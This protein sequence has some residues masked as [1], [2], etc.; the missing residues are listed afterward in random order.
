GG[1]GDDRVKSICV[2]EDGSI[3]FTGYFEETI[4]FS[5]KKEK[6]AIK[7]SAGSSDMYITKLSSDGLFCWSRKFGGSGVD[8]GNFCIVS[9]SKIYVT[10]YFYK[11]V[12]FAAEWNKSDI[13]KSSGT[14]DSFVIVID[15]KGNYVQTYKISSTDYCFAWGMC[16][17]KAQ[18]IYIT[19]EFHGLITSDTGN[20]TLQTTSKGIIDV[21]IIK[22]E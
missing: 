5:N 18:K 17:D 19:G 7:T 14:S 20:N 11:E 8:I 3:Y 13:K 4:D 22:I 1:N 12:N 21:F 16:A 2:G 10:G 9:K 6:N 15:H